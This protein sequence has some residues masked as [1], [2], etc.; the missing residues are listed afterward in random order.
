MIGPEDV[1]RIVIAAEWVGFAFPPKM[2]D[3]LEIR[4]EAGRFVVNDPLGRAEGEVEPLRIAALLDAIG[5]PPI[6]ALDPG[7]FSAPEKDVIDHFGALW[8]DDSPRFRVKVLLRDGGLIASGSTSQHA[9]MLPWAVCRPGDSGE[10]ETFNPRIAWAITDLIPEG[11]LERDRLEGRS[12]VFD[13]D[14][15]LMD[16]DDESVDD[17]AEDDEGAEPEEIVATRARHRADEGESQGR[18]PRIGP[19]SG[20]PGGETPEE[21]DPARDPGTGGDGPL[22]GEE[23]QE[24]EGKLRS[25]ELLRRNR[26]IAQ[27]EELLGLGA[28]PNVADAMGQT[29][30]MLATGPPFDE[31]RFGLLVGA[32]ADVNARRLDGLTGL[33]LA[34][35]GGEERVARAWIAAGADVNMKVDEGGLSALMLAVSHYWWP[36]IVSAL[37]EAGAE[38][39]ATD[40]EGRTALMFAVRREPE[41]QVGKQRSAVTLLIEA[42]ADVNARDGSGKTVLDHAEQSALTERIGE[43][44]RAEFAS[45][46]DAMPASAPGSV[47]SD[48]LSERLRSAGARR[49][50]G[51]TE[52]SP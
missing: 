44:V 8:E 33:H 32:G 2:A 16:L 35:G 11:F 14:R 29:A 52:G 25:T 1:D 50:V 3:R 6:T 13:P 39:D 42:G 4:A 40:D 37:L 18:G 20:P 38:V 15:G 45:P 36:G 7:A 24:P 31:E 22:D 10:V 30:L 26:S 12:L 5:A 34:A 51:K 49:S 19:E 23:R 47:A 17:D 28:D 9:Y 43:Q 46:L 27:V 48:W 41:S 21:G